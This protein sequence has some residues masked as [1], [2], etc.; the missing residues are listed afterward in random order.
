MAS[1][2]LRRSL[3]RRD[4]PLELLLLPFKLI[5]FVFSVIIGLFSL[6]ISNFFFLPVFVLQLCGWVLDPPFQS[7]T[8]MI[9][10]M[11]LVSLPGLASYY[12]SD[13]LGDRLERTCE[14][15]AKLTSGRVRC[16][17]A[18]ERLGDEFEQLVKDPAEAM[19][20]RVYWK[21]PNHALIGNMGPLHYHALLSVRREVRDDTD[22]KSFL[23]SIMDLGFRIRIYQVAREKLVENYE[24]DRFERYAKVQL[25]R[26][27]VWRMATMQRM[28]RFEAIVLLGTRLAADIHKRIIYWTK[29]PPT[30][31]RKDEQLINYFSY[32]SHGNLD[33]MLY[34]NWSSNFGFWEQVFYLASGVSSILYSGLARIESSNKIKASFSDLRSLM[35]IYGAIVCRLY[36]AVFDSRQCA[37][38]QVLLMRCRVFDYREYQ[39]RKVSQN[40]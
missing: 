34:A 21:Y 6:I 39:H 11:I 37:S 33:D 32:E 27:T 40:Q 29:T 24:D 35:G 18:D 26:S 23:Q 15:Y 5:V 14:E 12:M 30:D 10:D 2:D 16:M 7:E 8:N 4:G 19:F 31:L 20:W 22:F 36:R 3:R 38:N 13:D 17:I 9:S 25:G 28:A 1:G